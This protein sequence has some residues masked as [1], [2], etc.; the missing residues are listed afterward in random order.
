MIMEVFKEKVKRRRITDVCLMLVAVVLGIFCVISMGS[1]A[2]DGTMAEGF[3][4]GFQFGLVISIGVLSLVDFIKLSQAI[5]DET[6]LRMLYN[7]EHD[8]RMKAIRSKA[9]Q[10]LLTITSVLMI[11]AAIIAGYFNFIVFFT[12]VAAVL[13]QLAVSAG[14]KLVCMK[15]M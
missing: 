3:V 4:A 10:P 5:K 7:K 2:D 13:G 9:G 15:K 6:K 1:Q 14:V 8:E 11:I 12:L